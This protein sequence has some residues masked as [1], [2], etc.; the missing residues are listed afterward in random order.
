MDATVVACILLALV[1]LSLSAYTFMRDRH[2][3]DAYRKYIERSQNRRDWDNH[4]M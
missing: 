4:D 1:A 3:E 2:R